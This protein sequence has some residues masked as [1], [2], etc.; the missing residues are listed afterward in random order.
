MDARTKQTV[1]VVV[2]QLFGE[3]LA[4]LIRNGPIWALRS[5]ANERAIRKLWATPNL[6]PD[7]V[8]YFEPG[9]GLISEEA[10]CYVLDTIDQ[11]HPDW[12]EMRVYGAKLTEL[13]RANFAT[14]WEGLFYE[15][16]EGFVFVRTRLPTPTRLNGL[17]VSMSITGRRK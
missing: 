16:D 14:F 4:D 15:I 9:N 10:V 12:I 5:E 8:T 13:V 3:R 7:H 1:F 6:P 2:D 11:H 17:S